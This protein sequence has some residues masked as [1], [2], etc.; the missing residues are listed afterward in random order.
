[1]KS[2]QRLIVEC[3]IAARECPPVMAE[4]QQLIIDKL[5]VM[6][7]HAIVTFSWESGT[8]EEQ[9][10]KQYAEPGRHTLSGRQLEIALLLCKHHSIRKIAS[11]LHIT[12]NTVKKHIQNIKRAY[13]LRSTGLDFLYEL[14]NRLN[15]EQAGGVLLADDINHSIE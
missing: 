10:Q 8:A 2:K 9:G 1:M 11:Q 4:L 3:E 6:D 12:D 7:G 15:G 5:T 14:Q 13:R